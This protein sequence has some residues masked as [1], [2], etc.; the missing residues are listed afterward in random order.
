MLVVVVAALILMVQ[1]GLVEKDKLVVV[2]EAQ[3]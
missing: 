1:L 2:L 3:Y